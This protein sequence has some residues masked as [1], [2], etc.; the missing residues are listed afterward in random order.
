MNPGLKTRG[1]KDLK[2]KAV[3]A[4]GMPGGLNR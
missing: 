3:K 2:N 1:L 4:A